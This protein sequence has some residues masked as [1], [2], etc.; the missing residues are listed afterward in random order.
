MTVID[1]P[2]IEPPIALPIPGIIVALTDL[3]ECVCGLLAT[4]GA[5]EPC[6]CGIHPGAQVSWD[7][8]S[9]GECSSDM[10]GMAWVRPDLVFPY[11]SFPLPVVDPNCRKPLAWRVEVGALRCM[12]QPST[13]ELLTP[14]ESMAVTWGQIL[15][16][17]AIHKALQ[18]C[19][20]SVTVEGYTPVGPQGGCVGGFWVGYV[21]VAY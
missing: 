1:P 13:G 5:G 15:D 19:D 16:A 14:V 3:I 17:R 6:W 20:V 9:G 12:P 8:C 21:D 18:C 11:D 4:E 10:C 2:V 7:Y